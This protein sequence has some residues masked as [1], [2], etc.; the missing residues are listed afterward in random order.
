V[1]GLTTD[2]L[3]A[4]GICTGRGVSELVLQSACPASGAGV[5]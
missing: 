4:D 2:E 5:L 1:Q 3:N